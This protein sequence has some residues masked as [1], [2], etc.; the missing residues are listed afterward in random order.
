M[1]T[2][3]I[4]AN[5]DTSADSSPKLLSRIKQLYD[6]RKPL[7]ST[8][9]LRKPGRFCV[10][11]SE[12]CQLFG[13]SRLRGDSIAMTGTAEHHFLAAFVATLPKL[14]TLSI[15][16]PYYG[17]L[18]L[19]TLVGMILRV[20]HLETIY[21]QSVDDEIFAQLRQA[22]QKR[23]WQHES[24]KQ[25][26]RKL[27]WAPCLV[28]KGEVRFTV[29]LDE[30]K[31]SPDGLSRNSTQFFIVLR[32]TAQVQISAIKGYLDRKVQFSTNVQVALNFMDH[33][34]RQWS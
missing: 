28:D 13:A 30:G 1:Y 29:D 27:A 32:A 17:L 18:E 9:E 21:M 15:W 5:Q 33:F 7:P 11:P 20:T 19:A 24:T 31:T 3:G 10:F 25:A 26:L 12:R 4:E 16:S 22:A 34:L 2:S 23:I 6:A 14:R 8:D